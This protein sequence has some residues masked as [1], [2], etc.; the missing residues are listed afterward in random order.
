MATLFKHLTLQIEFFTRMSLVS[1]GAGGGL[2]GLVHEPEL[3]SQ[4][5][6]RRISSLHLLDQTT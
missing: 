5:L 4:H 2:G 1:E 3:L 6:H